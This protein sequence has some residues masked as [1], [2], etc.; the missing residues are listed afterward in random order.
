MFSLL[1]PYKEGAMENY[2]LPSLAEAS[3]CA[4]RCRADL[5]A[6]QGAAATSSDSYGVVAFTSIL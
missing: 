4:W 2:F 3:A 1:S 6:Q 5:E